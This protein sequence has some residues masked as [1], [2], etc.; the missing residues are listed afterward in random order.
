MGLRVYVFHF[1][2]DGH[3]C[4]IPLARWNRI[5]RQDEA[6][7]GHENLTERVAYA[8][9]ELAQRKPIF[10]S[11]IQG[12]LYRFD[13]SGTLDRI[14]LTAYIRSPLDA[15]AVDSEV[16]Q[17]VV[18][19]AENRFLMRRYRHTCTWTLSSND[20]NKIIAMIW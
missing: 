2:A 17:P 7:Q 15:L 20:V 11:L 19:N 5:W 8:Y 9:V 12:S 6:W 18:V 13:T 4:R 10:C 16:S 1:H 3:V 14:F